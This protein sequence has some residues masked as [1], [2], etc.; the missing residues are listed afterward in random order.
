MSLWTFATFLDLHMLIV[1]VHTN[2]HAVV[3]FMR[4][5]TGLGDRSTS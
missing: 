3:C 5:G 4:S 1:H 2:T